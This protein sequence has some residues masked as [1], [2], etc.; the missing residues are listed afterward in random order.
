MSRRLELFLALA[1]LLPTPAAAL[2]SDRYQPIHVQ[3]DRLE[4]D[5]R[6]GIST[7]RG[8]VVLE[9]GSLRLEADVLVVHRKGDALDRLEAEGRPVRFR[10]LPDG[11]TEMIEG[12]ARRLEYRAAQ[13]Q[14]LLQGTASVRQAGNLFSGERIEYDI[15]KSRVRASGQTDDGDGRVRAIIQPRQPAPEGVPKP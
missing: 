11:S 14:L 2:E 15:V 7:Y 1:L 5:N 9:Q 13:D 12:E 10:Q 4:L 8:N 6:L 3:A